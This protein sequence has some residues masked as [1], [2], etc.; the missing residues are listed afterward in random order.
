MT[1]WSVADLCLFSRAL[2]RVMRSIPANVRIELTTEEMADT[3][4]A[5]LG[6]KSCLQKWLS[7]SWALPPARQYRLLT[8][9]P[10]TA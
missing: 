1:D 9:C 6:T 8:A 2:E 10:P 3:R 5:V 7:T 4:P